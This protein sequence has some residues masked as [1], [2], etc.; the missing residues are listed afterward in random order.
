MIVLFIILFL[1]VSLGYAFYRAL[2][3]KY[4]EEYFFKTDGMT[5]EE[6]EHRKFKGRPPFPY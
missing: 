6:I 1:I 5:K 3:E 4:P 2:T